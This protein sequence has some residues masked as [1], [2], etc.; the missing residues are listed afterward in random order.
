MSWPE[1]QDC[2]RTCCW[3]SSLEN[4]IAS[5][6]RSDVFRVWFPN[7]LEVFCDALLIWWLHLI[8]FAAYSPKR[9]A[10]SNGPLISCTFIKDLW[11]SYFRL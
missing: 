11:Q 10:Y 4:W 5:L 1:F 9:S 3:T 2:P 6:G 7:D 8:G